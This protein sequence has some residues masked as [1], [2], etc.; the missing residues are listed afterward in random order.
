MDLMFTKGRGLFF[1]VV[2]VN[3]HHLCGGNVMIG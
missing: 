2:V 3:N 1:V